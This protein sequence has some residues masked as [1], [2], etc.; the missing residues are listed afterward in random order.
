MRS[1]RVL[2]SVGELPR[3]AVARTLRTHP[4]WS[5]AS[6]FGVIER[7]GPRADTLGR[8]TIAELLGGD[9]SEDCPY[10]DRVR[11]ARALRQ[12][13]AKFDQVVFDVLCEARGDVGAGYLRERV[14]GP[15]W[16]LQ[17][18]LGRLVA[19]G[20][21]VRSGNT[22]TTRYHAVMVRA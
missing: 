10:I 3:L 16:K 7:G 5:L 2:E 4:E 14:G 6:V 22:S 20:R 1:S 19:A 17:D 13:G 11:L 18:S 8:L 12:R 15:R 9:A 21:V